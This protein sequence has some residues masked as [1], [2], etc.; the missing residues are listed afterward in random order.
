MPTKQK[1]IIGVIGATVLILLWQVMGLFKNNTPEAP[2]VVTTTKT[3]TTSDASST[4]ASAETPQ[5]PPGAQAQPP[6]QPQ[7]S[8]V[9]LR[10]DLEFLKLQQDVQ[11]KYLG[12]INQLQLLRLQKEIAEMNQAIAASKLAT[13]TAEKNI[14]DLLTT[15]STFPTV[16]NP[17]VAPA[18]P[19]E[20][21]PTEAPKAPPMTKVE[22]YKVT[23]VSMQFDKWTAI[24]DNNGKLY[25]VSIGDVLPDSGEKVIKINMEGV[26]LEKDNIK[27]KVNLVAAI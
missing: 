23:S 5:T 15:S 13:V 11:Q 19:T 14:A 12:S 3:T 22:Q 20:P 8:E 9:S 4:S 1:V 18:T 10:K 16:I 6:G 2:A 26:V 7:I 17:M 27:T 21:V 24:L 25:H